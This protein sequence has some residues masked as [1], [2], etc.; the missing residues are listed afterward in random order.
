MSKITIDNWRSAL[1]SKY[2]ERFRDFMHWW[3]EGLLLNIPKNMRARMMS[4]TSR[5]VLAV[6]KSKADLI[7]EKE[8]SQET[9][10][11]LNEQD[12]ELR[13]GLRTVDR[14]KKRPFI[15]RIPS[16][17]ALVKKVA[18]PAAAKNNLNQVLGFEMDRLTPFSA[19]DVYYDCRA[20]SKANDA[21]QILVE[22]VVVPR[23]KIDHWL[24]RLKENA[25]FPSA[26]EVTGSWAGVNL[27]PLAQRP[28]ADRGDM[29]AKILLF[30][31]FIVL[32]AAVLITP[33]WQ[34]REIALGLKGKVDKLKSR[35]DSVLVL[36]EEV[37]QGRKT[38]QAVVKKREA[39]PPTLDV[40]KDLTE[41]LPD[42]TW[43]QQ[44]DMKKDTVEVRGMSDGADTLIKLIED[45]MAFENVRFRSPVV[46]Q[47]GKERFHLSARLMVSGVEQ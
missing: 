47:Q 20:I 6:D 22:F 41:L 29:A 21:G 45:S 27:L 40:I 28:K 24:S 46:Q 15:L 37:E 36:R 4:S 8:A 43:V 23:V 35:S 30:L 14:S 1:D 9:L 5:Y 32:L 39:L 44:L 2:F 17:W 18:L 38:L 25:C 19:D 10:F 33:L 3:K 34:Q 12:D 13:H 11:E 16:S 26:V 7:L 31:V 42:H